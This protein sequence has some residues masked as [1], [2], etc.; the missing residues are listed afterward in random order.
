MPIIVIMKGTDDFV[1]GMCRFGP[2][3]NVSQ[4]KPIKH[5]FGQVTIVSL[6]RLF[7]IVSAVPSYGKPGGLR[8]VH[9]GLGT[10]VILHPGI[11]YGGR[12]STIVSPY[13]F[14]NLNV[15]RDNGGLS[16]RQLLDLHPVGQAAC[17]F[18]QRH[19]VKE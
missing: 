4:C 7:F 14:P 5:F 13:P 9:K 11:V 6:G 12:L 2:E 1:L 3:K 10:A 19:Y 15:R 8:S 18:Y 17:R 16:S